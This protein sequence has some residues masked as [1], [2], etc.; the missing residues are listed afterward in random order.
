VE[1]STPDS[2]T[3]IGVRWRGAGKNPR[4]RRREGEGRVPLWWRV[5]R[6]AAFFI[7]AG[8]DARAERNPNARPGAA[9]SPWRCPNIGPP[10]DGHRADGHPQTWALSSPATALWFLRGSSWQCK[11]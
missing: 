4:R 11:R 1:G 8:R 10:R 5:G 7:G 2:E 3:R 9:L 6:V